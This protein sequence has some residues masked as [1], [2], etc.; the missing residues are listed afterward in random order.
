MPQNLLI[1]R[2]AMKIQDYLC[3]DVSDGGEVKNTNTNSYLKKQI[4]N[5][6]YYR[7]ELSKAG[8]SKKLFV[9]RLVALAFI[10]NIKNLPQVNHKDGDKLN[11]NVS[12]LEWVTASNNKK[13]SFRVLGQTVTKLFDGDNGKTK[14]KK[15]NIQGLIERKKETTY[16][17]L[18]K[19]IGVNPKYL[20][21]LL[22]GLVR[23]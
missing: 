4:N 18:A 6:G 15:E 10:P 21:N 17:A 20:S 1:W 16:K 13:H 23:G 7:V 22:R 8:R 14:I 12:N 19:E 3:Y 2:I 5:S 9:H 11:N